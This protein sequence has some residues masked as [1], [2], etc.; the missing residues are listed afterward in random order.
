MLTGD[1][2]TGKTHVVLA[3]GNLL[4]EQNDSQ[5]IVYIAEFPHNVRI[6]KHFKGN[7]NL[8]TLLSL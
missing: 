4:F 3:I 8:Y 1:A 5:S 7:N 6:E 2:G